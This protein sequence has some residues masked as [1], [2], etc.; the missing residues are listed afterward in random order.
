MTSWSLSNVNGQE[1]V[2]PSVSPWERAG[3]T[4][5]MVCWVGAD[6]VVTDAATGEAVEL[7][8]LDRHARREVQAAAQRLLNQIGRWSS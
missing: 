2:L 5:L 8:E 4:G 3:E 7:G 1:V 6:L